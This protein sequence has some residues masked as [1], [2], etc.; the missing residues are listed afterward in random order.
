MKSRLLV[1]FAVWLSW[2]ALQAGDLSTQDY[3]AAR[4]VYTS[5]CARCH[6]FYEPSDYGD[7]EWELWM[8]KMRKKARLNA[9]DYDL[10][11]RLTDAM[12]HTAKGSNPVSKT[13]ET[14]P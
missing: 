3:A 7:A 1:V 6:K 11:V 2:S 8:G 9:R 10:V 12:R 5:K 4:K 14:Q 13:Q